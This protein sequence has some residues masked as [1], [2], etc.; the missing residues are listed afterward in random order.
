[1]KERTVFLLED[2]PLITTE[3]EETLEEF[4]WTVAHKASTVEDG[5][6]IAQECVF[7]VAILDI[8]LGERESNPIALVVSKRHI[9]IIICTGYHSESLHGKYPGIRILEKPFSSERL[10]E[11]LEEIWV[12]RQ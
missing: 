8:K 7:H 9:P 5:M 10:R 6:Q 4:G 2:D 1:M 11:M 3:L 12:S